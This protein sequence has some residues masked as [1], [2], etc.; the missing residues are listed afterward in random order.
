MSYQNFIKDKRVIFVGPAKTLIGKSNGEFI[1]SHDVVIRT[2]GSFPV[3]Q[4]LHADYGKRCDSLY[5]NMY[6]SKNGNMPI[7][8]YESANLKFISL[9]SDPKRLSVRFRNSNINFRIITQDFISTRRRLKVAPLMG[10]YIIDEVLRMRPASIHITG[11]SFYSEKDINSH[12]ISNYLPKT[13]NP[14]I[15]DDIRLKHHKQEIQNRLV[16]DWIVSGQISADEDIHRILK[17]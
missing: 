3:D 8:E 12:Y 15:L 17:V 1:D 4:S 5:V 6:Y 9:K 16:K 7:G 10:T 13:A 11:M 2:N 14:K